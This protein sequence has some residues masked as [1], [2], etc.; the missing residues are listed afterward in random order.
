MDAIIKG[1]VVFC[2]QTNEEINI[3]KLNAGLTNF[4]G[5]SV[6]ISS[7]NIKEFEGDIIALCFGF[8]NN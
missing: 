1:D 7:D 6:S 4:Y 3:L 5:Q 2:P 8:E